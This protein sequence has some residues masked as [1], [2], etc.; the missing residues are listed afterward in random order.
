M[1]ARY[2]STRQDEVNGFSCECGD[3][4]TGT[5]CDQEIVDCMADSCDF[6]T[7]HVSLHDHARAR[8]EMAYLTRMLGPQ[9]KSPPPGF[10]CDCDAGYTGDVCDTEINECDPMPCQNGGICTVSTYI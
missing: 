5:T 1:D 2:A 10:E 3:G 8:G 7:C 4:Y 6:G 9:E